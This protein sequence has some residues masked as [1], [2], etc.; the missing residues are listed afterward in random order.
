MKSNSGGM[1]RAVFGADK[2]VRPL[3][4]PGELRSMIGLRLLTLRCLVV[5]TVVDKLLVFLGGG[6]AGVA[7][8]EE[9][10]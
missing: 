2:V 3:E 4:C 9:A 7:L 8:T 10:E 5:D 1:D 6:V